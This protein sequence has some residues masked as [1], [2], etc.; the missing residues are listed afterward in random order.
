MITYIKGDA[1]VPQAKG[2]KLIVHIV[3]T[4]GGWGK[5]FVLALS[6]RWPEPEANYRRWQRLKDPIHD[7]TPGKIVMTSGRF[8]LGETQLVLVQPGLA[9]VNMVAQE[10]MK[11]GSKGP[12]IRYEALLNCLQL[13]N[14]Y[15]KTMGPLS[16]HA[17][18]IG[19]GLAGGVWSKVEPLIQEALPDVPVTIYDF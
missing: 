17:P 12:P 18:R 3:N 8:A 14:G 10:G 19:C 6:K 16:V 4:L 15:A 1:T 7:G 2:T 13:V 5:G 11:T 9:V